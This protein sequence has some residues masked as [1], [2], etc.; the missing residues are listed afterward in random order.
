MVVTHSQ[1]AL[2]AKE[3]SCN[4]HFAVC[5]FPEHLGWKNEMQ[6]NVSIFGNS[7]KNLIL[8]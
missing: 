4:S 8:L 3:L 1:L 6:C 2:M 5:G 7:E